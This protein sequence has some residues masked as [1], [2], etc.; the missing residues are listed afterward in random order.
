MQTPVNNMHMGMCKSWAAVQKKKSLYILA[1]STIYLWKVTE[2]S[3]AEDVVLNL[4]K[5][6]IHHKIRVLVNV[7]YL[8]EKTKYYHGS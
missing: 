2:F 4:L 6:L 5:K 1:Y 8:Q 3:I 7:D